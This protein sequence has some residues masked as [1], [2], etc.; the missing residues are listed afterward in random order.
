LVFFYPRLFN[1]VW[2]EGMQSPYLRRPIQTTTMSRVSKIQTFLMLM[3][4]EQTT[5]TLQG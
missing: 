3:L 4:V 5:V 1:V 2:G